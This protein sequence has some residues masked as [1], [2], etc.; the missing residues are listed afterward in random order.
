MTLSTCNVTV[1]RKTGDWTNFCPTKLRSFLRG[2]PFDRCLFAYQTTFPRVA[3]SFRSFVDFDSLEQ[4][5]HTRST[6]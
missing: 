4:L 6:P 2:T 3:A 5:W 1:I